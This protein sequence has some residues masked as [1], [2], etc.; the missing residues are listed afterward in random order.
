MLR[1]LSQKNDVAEVLEFFRGKGPHGARVVRLWVLME[2]TIP[3]VQAPF[4]EWDLNGNALHLFSA[5]PRLVLLYLGC[6]M[7]NIARVALSLLHLALYWKESRPDV[8]RTI[9][10]HC[11]RLNDKFI[12]FHNMRDMGWLNQKGELSIEVFERITCLVKV[13]YELKAKVLDEWGIRRTDQQ[14]EIVNLVER[15]SKGSWDDTNEHY[16]NWEFCYFEDSAIIASKWRPQD[17]PDFVAASENDPMWSRAMSMVDGSIDG[18]YAVAEKAL[19]YGSWHMASSA[20]AVKDAAA[21]LGVDVHDCS[22]REK[23][24]AKLV[25]AGWTYL[26]YI[27]RKEEASRGRVG[28]GGRDELDVSF[29]DACRT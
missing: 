13:R 10:G 17:D 9:G 6:G 16:E 28:R 20:K 22:N 29:R 14:S 23:T 24:S 11:R 8:L 18:A 26:D 7:P 12:E 4:I 1:R 21:E 2:H 5:L 27:I 15:Y 25:E 3:L 19:V